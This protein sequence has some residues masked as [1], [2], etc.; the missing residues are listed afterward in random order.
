MRITTQICA[1]DHVQMTAKYQPV[2][3]K[4]RARLL[5]QNED[6]LVHLFNVFGS[7]SESIIDPLSYI[8]SPRSGPHTHCDIF[9]YCIQRKSVKIPEE[10]S[11]IYD[12]RDD[13][14][15]RRTRALA[16]TTGISLTSKEHSCSH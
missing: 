2:E 8:Y 11:F 15:S 13:T 3:L 1:V 14:G 10:L 16:L 12:L 9:K 7:R 5:S 4:G 6:A